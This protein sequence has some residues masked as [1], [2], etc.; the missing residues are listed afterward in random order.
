MP[1]SHSTVT[2]EASG[3]ITGGSCPP[4]AF[5]GH[6]VSTP[7]MPSPL[8]FGFRDKC[9]PGGSTLWSHQLQFLEASYEL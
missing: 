9:L 2:A 1:D 8:N 3:D 5:N 6:Y 4:S 7:I